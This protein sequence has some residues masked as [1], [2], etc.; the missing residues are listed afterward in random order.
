M[1]RTYRIVW[2]AARNAFIVTHE[3]AKT[4]GKPSSTRKGVVSA[5]AAALLAM[6]A[7]PAMAATDCLTPGVIIIDG[8]ATAGCGL[9][10]GDSLTV[11][12][13]GLI[14]PTAGSVAA[15]TVNAVTVG[16]INNNGTISQLSSGTGIN[17]TSGGSV[18]SIVNSGTISGQWAG[19]WVGWGS[20]ITGG[21]DNQ[22]GGSI[23]GLFSGGIA[24]TSSSVSGGITNAGTI[25][26]SGS[27]VVLHSV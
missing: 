1:N 4:K 17:V 23:S 25:S 26:N 11:T 19:I 10:G 5:V 24:V 2:N 12:S 6:A 7:T 21:I 13:A 20:A 15:V 8:A 14:I 3:N 18:G 9:A 22:A 27:S 16:D